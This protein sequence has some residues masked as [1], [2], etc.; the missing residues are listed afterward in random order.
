[1]LGRRQLRQRGGRGGRD[2]LNGHIAEI[3]VASLPRPLS[4]IPMA[5]L[6]SRVRRCTRLPELTHERRC[7]MPSVRCQSP[8]VWTR[9]YRP[10]SPPPSYT[11]QDDGYSTSMDQIS[12][13]WWTP[14][15]SGDWHLD[16]VWAA[17]LAVGPWTH[18][19]SR[20]GGGV[21]SWTSS[22]SPGGPCRLCTLLIRAGGQYVS[23]LKTAH[24]QLL[25]AHAE[26][27]RMG[28]RVCWSTSGRAR[29]LDALC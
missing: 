19:V 7:D 3:V 15:H 26:G 4:D 20:Y 21:R 17:A 25:Y 10:P 23:E 11:V 12:R 22:V 18:R 2:R 8:R 27:L 1:V 28:L 9:G 13:D 14:E 6:M 29:P 5:S 16:R 24:L